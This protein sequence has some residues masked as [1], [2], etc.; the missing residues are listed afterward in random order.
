MGQLPD[1]IRD[2]PARTG[3]I[4][5][6]HWTNRVGLQAGVG[7]QGD[8]L[9]IGITPGLN[10]TF[11]LLERPF[12]FTLAAPIRLEL[13][14]ARAEDRFGHVGRLLADDWNEPGD[15]LQVLQNLTWG[16]AKGHFLIGFHQFE[17]AFL[18]HG[19][20]VRRYAPNLVL[21]SHGL[22]FK[23]DAF[24]DWAG[25]EAYVDDVAA[26]HV[27]GGRARFNPLAFVSRENPYLRT[28]YLG[29]TIAADV[30]APL[31]NHLDLDDVDDDGRRE[32]EVRVD[33]DHLTPDY[34]S[35]GVIAWG[36]DLGIRLAETEEIAYDTYIDWSFLTGAVPDDDPANPRFTGVP[37]RGVRTS[38]V[39]WGHTLRVDLGSNLR[40]G[41]RARVEYR[42]HEAGYQP[43][44]FGLGYDV[45][46]TQASKGSRLA[47]DLA[48]RT[49]AQS[50]LGRSGRR[51]NGGLI[52]I[53]YLLGRYL[54]AGIGFEFT[55]RFP[56]NHMFIT[57]GV[58]NYKDFQ[59]E[60]TYHRRNARDFVDLWHWFDPDSSDVLVAERATP[61]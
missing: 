58:P 16:D 14:D 49:K 47:T 59:F 54:E 51:V 38:G 18:G 60:F 20:L 36:V 57:V 46:R 33:P 24:S 25:G 17:A 4:G 55:E 37:T 15:Y 32:G 21:C 50:V 44:Y 39:T 5:A 52:E 31:R 29:F 10:V 7:L 9:T 3:A 19:T 61:S 45:E 13:V 35:T 23:A 11:P 42:N 28:F 56:D 12:S 34:L 41:L 1:A 8:L 26:P 22:A 30:D 48:N 53:S 40:H 43:G 2:D 27:V 6:L